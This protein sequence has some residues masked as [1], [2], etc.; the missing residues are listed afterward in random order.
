M[1]FF[2]LIACAS[3]ANE[4]QE[5]IGNLELIAYKYI[6]ADYYVF[7]NLVF[8]IDEAL[9]SLPF[10]V[11]SCTLFNE[12][13]VEL[14]SSLEGAGLCLYSLAY[15]SNDSLDY[16]IIES[17]LSTEQKFKLKVLLNFKTNLGFFGYD[18]Y[19]SWSN[20]KKL[21]LDLDMSVTLLDQDEFFEKLYNDATY[22]FNNSKKDSVLLDKLYE[23]GFFDSAVKILPTSFSVVLDPSV[24]VENQL[25]III[26]THKG[27]SYKVLS[28]S[29][30]FLGAKELNL[31][32][33]RH[34]EN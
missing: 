24:E 8:D 10:E 27:I 34:N 7:K 11:V 9:S 4:E 1:C 19:D 5:E 33:M 2:S 29:D 32:G 30:I 16:V 26:K 14:Q 18:Y 23:S 31:K 12:H 20:S 13:G 15:S 3:H 22:E 21:P 25:E 6:K 17:K 28:L